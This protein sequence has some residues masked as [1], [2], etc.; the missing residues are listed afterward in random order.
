[1]NLFFKLSAGTWSSEEESANHSYKNMWLEH[2]DREIVEIL[3]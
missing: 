2:F 1:M 3:L